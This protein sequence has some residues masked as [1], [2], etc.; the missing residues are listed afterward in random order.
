VR[1]VTVQGKGQVVHHLCSYV[2]RYRGVYLYHDVSWRNSPL[3]SLIGV[4]TVT[5]PTT[6]TT[7]LLCMTLERFLALRYPRRRPGVLA[8]HV[9]GAVT[10]AVALTLALVSVSPGL[11][12]SLYAQSALCVPVSALTAA[13]PAH[14]FGLGV[15]T[16]LNL[17]TSLLACAACLWLLWQARRQDGDLISACR[18]PKDRLK[19]VSVARRVADVVLVNGLSWLPASLLSLGLMLNTAWQ[20]KGLGPEWLPSLQLLALCLKCAV[21][22]WLY[23]LAGM[24]QRRRQEQRDRLL[25]WLDAQTKRRVLQ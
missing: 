16:V 15:S 2:F 5:S 13:S 6:S 23:V 8:A 21:T 3:C 4:L 1:L 9:T 19:E 18:L 24:Q 25:Q 20:E 7:L 14:H 11:A 12:P 22:P 17:L 10:W